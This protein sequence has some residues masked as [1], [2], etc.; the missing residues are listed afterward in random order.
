MDTSCSFKHDAEAAKKDKD[1]VYAFRRAQVGKLTEADIKAFPLD[2][3]AAECSP[4]DDGWTFEHIQG[5]IEDGGPRPTC[6]LELQL[7]C[8]G[9]EP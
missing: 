9:R 5:Y 8:A 6:L 2:A 7:Q 1:L 4:A 3:N